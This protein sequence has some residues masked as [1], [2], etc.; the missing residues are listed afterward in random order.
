MTHTDPRTARI[1]HHL[2]TGIMLGLIALG[3]LPVPLDAAQ[4]GKTEVLP[5]QKAAPA[6]VVIDTAG[7][8]AELRRQLRAKDGVAE[9]HTATVRFSQ[10]P[11]G[12]F[13]FIA[14]QFL[15]MA[16]V[17]QSP[18]LVLERVPPA[19]NAYEIH[20]LADGS[21]MLVGFI[22]QE[23]IAQVTPSNRLKN[24]RVALYS[25]PSEKAPHIAAV[26][27][28]K[29]MVDR[30]PVRLDPKKPDS[31][32]MLDMDLQGTANRKSVPGAQ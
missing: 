28:V 31:A 26:P 16:L 32:V 9:L 8:E 3:A 1:A 12:S 30:M 24:I 11:T 10:A 29:L 21:G 6:A 22:G 2:L 13:G 17:T 15:G 4:G 5:V 25:N 20:K 14:P 18:D 23:L 27:L 7:S 19:A